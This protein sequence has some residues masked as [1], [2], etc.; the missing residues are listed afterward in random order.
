LE[1]NSASI[2]K[3]REFYDLPIHQS[4]VPH[5]EGHRAA[6]LGEQ[7]L[8]RL[9]VLVFDS[10]A[11]TNG[12]KILAIANAFNPASHLCPTSVLPVLCTARR[13][14]GQAVGHSQSPGNMETGRKSDM[15]VFA[16][17]ARFS[18]FVTKS[19]TSVRGRLEPMIL[20]NS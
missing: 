14:S 17:L 10:A 1:V 3:C 2:T 19:K 18:S 12:D 9:G 6:L 20:S 11:D 7:R 16:A 13:L 8:Q 5:I 4:H 15:R